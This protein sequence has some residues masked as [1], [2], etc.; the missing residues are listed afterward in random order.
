[1]GVV[2]LCGGFNAYTLR[3]GSGITES[4]GVPLFDITFSQN[5]TTLNDGSS[6][7]ACQGVQCSAIDITFATLE[8]TSLGLLSLIVGEAITNPYI[9][10]TIVGVRCC[11][12]VYG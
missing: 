10:F 8:L 4:R 7:F 1:M 2:I 11:S 5:F 12:H 3:W 9:S 6:M